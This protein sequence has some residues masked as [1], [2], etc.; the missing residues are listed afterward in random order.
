MKNKKKRSYNLYITFTLY[1][2]QKRDDIWERQQTKN[3]LN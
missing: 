3:A 1:P 2:T